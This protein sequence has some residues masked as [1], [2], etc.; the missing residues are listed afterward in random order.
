M[1]CMENCVSTRQEL[2]DI[3]DCS[4]DGL[5]VLSFLSS[6]VLALFDS[7]TTIKIWALV[8]LFATC[9]GGAV[10]RQRQS[11]RNPKHASSGRDGELQPTGCLYST[12]SGAWRIFQENGECGMLLL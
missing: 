6:L 12:D 4:E 8:V 1:F 10:G 7:T 3:N 9:A 5:Q 11:A 2:S